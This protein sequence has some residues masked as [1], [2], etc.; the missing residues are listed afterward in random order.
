MAIELGPGSCLLAHD[1]N[2]K[3]AIVIGECEL[4]EERAADA[5]CLERLKAIKEAAQCM[6]D[7]LKVHQCELRQ[8]A[9][10]VARQAQPNRSFSH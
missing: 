9:V 8:L 2:N 5:H 4:L 6:A 10:A 7:A 3:L 1:L